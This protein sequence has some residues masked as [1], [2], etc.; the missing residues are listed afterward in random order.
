[1][2]KRTIKPLFVEFF[3]QIPNELDLLFDVLYQVHLLLFDIVELDHYKQEDYDDLY[4][5]LIVMNQ[6]YDQFF[7]LFAS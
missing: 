2:L 3:V 4:L 7:V 6:L 1:L 5:Y